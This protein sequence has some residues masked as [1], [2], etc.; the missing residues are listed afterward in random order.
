MIKTFE[1]SFL[2]EF[3]QL[4]SKESLVQLLN[5]IYNNYAKISDPELR[6]KKYFTEKQINFYLHNLNLPVIEDEHKLYSEFEIQ[7]KSGSKRIIHAPASPD[8][9]DL[10]SCIDYLV[11]SIYQPHPNAYGFIEGKNIADNA[12]LHLQKNYVYNIDLKDFF[13]SFDLNRVKLSLFN[14]PFNLKGDL[15][16]LAYTLASLVTCNLDGRRVLPQGSPVSPALTNHICWRLDHR[17][18]GLAKRFGLSYSRYADDITFSSNHN[19]YHGEFINELKRIINLENLL[20]NPSK[21]RLQKRG[22]RQEVTGITVNQ[23]L[24]VSKRYI[25]QLRMYLN[26][27]EKYGIDKASELYCR[28]YQELRTPG[29]LFLNPGNLE[30]ILKGK[31]NYLSMVKGKD[32]VVYVKLANRYNL[33]F[34]QKTSKID[35]IILHWL[36][37][38]I[39]SARKKYYEDQLNEEFSSESEKVDIEDQQQIISEDKILEKAL[40]T[41]QLHPFELRIFDLAYGFQFKNKQQ[42]DAEY[43]ALAEKLVIDSIRRNKAIKEFIDKIDVLDYKVAI[44]FLKDQIKK[45]TV[46]YGSPFAKVLKEGV[47][48]YYQAFIIYKDK[49]ING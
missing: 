40:S 23:G 48:D 10:L 43:D 36:N 20:I 46:F 24:N 29:E 4:G 3:Y 16:P 17:L 31:L 45:D 2:E 28:D 32:D 38:G 41:K 39:D 6:G 22:E 42:R 44:D 11:R 35:E 27:C 15:E 12:R 21:T 7:K 34:K 26:Y 25:K 8:F 5:N 9:K 18:H 49:L 37:F 14:K 47:K 1:N 19:V 30:N 13:H 33:L